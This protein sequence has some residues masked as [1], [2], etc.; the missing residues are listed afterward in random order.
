MKRFTMLFLAIIPSFSF[1]QNVG[2]G[3]VTPSE[4]LDVN[5]NINVAGQ[6]KLA[7]NAGASNQILMKDATNNPVWG[8]LSEFKE[9]SGRCYFYPC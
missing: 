3:T 2:I 6:L 5:G 7:G 1:S 4:K 8:D 9:C